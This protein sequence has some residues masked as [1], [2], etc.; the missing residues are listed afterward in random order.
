M[1]DKHSDKKVFCSSRKKDQGLEIRE[2]MV[3]LQNLKCKGSKNRHAS[4]RTHRCNLCLQQVAVKATLPLL[5]LIWLQKIHAG[6]S[7]A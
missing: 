7:L 6:R 2:T 5:Q 1:Q 3:S 4:A